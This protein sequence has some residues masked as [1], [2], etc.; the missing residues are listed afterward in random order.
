MTVAHLWGP[1]DESQVVRLNTQF[2]SVEFLFFGATPERID[3]RP[4]SGKWS[5]CENLAHIGR[6]HEIFLERLHRMLTEQSPKFAQ[7]RVEEDVGWQQWQ[8]RHF[9]EI[10]T[11]LVA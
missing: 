10:R 6:Y 9:E 5:A 7:Y 8:S 3:R 1:F 4:A 11:R 2:S